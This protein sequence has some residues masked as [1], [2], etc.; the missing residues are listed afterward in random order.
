[1]NET[2]QNFL[3]RLPDDQKLLSGREE[4]TR[5]AAVLPILSQLG[6]DCYDLNQVYPEYGVGEGRV[7][8]CLSIG[9]RKAV[10][11][12][13]K[14][15]GADLED[16]ERQLLE[17]SFND[18]ISLAV[19]T[20]GLVWWFYLP[21][22]RGDWKE[23]KFF[24]IDLEKQEPNIIEKHFREFLSK[25][26]IE[27]KS[28]LSNARSLKKSKEKTKLLKEAIPIAWN[29]L[30]EEP[31]EN[32]IDL[33]A[34]KVEALSGHRP[35][36]ESITDFLDTLP[37]LQQDQIPKGKSVSR[38]KGTRKYSGSKLKG[39]EVEIG[40]RIIILSTVRSYYQEVLEYLVDGPFMEKI[41]P[42]I[43]YA[44]SPVRFLISTE[45]VHQRG[46]PFVG[47]ID[48]K[49]YYMEAHKSHGAALDHLEY[50]LLQCNI[51]FKRDSVGE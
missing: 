37:G 31:D 19:L 27:N 29:Q 10:F 35:A 41:E 16:H 15:C 26:S 28:A 20:N 6:W 1:M 36:I 34:D 48:Y 9:S 8:Y 45:P 33:F 22:E 5:Q 42:N 51:P 38:K 39:T 12:E 50:F 44:T 25:E 24:S 40:G 47:P 4:V 30:I 23:R 7:D 18:G 3:K 17:Y 14:R 21:L 49:G 43:P 13:V 32:L 11:V 2:F 46:N